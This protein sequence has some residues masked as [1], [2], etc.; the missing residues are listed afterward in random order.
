[1]GYF[2]PIKKEG[3][4]DTGSK[5]PGLFDRFV[6][7]VTGGHEDSQ[8]E[9]I[10]EEKDTDFSIRLIKEFGVASIPVS[11]FYQKATDYKIIR[12]CFAKENSTLAL[13]AEKLKNV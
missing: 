8:D 1:M 5:N 2:I 4:H 13:A 10:S 3:S 9:N 7:Y 12:F 11:A 6:S